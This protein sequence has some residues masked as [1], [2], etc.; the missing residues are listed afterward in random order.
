MMDL[1]LVRLVAFG[2]GLIGVPLLLA[3]AYRTWD[4]HHRAN[5]PHWRNGIGL[6]SVS[7]VA[8]VWLWFVLDL[9]SV[10]TGLGA[11]YIDGHGLPGNC[12]CLAAAFACAWKGR[13]RLEAVAACI[14]MV[15]GLS[16]LVYT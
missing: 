9:A 12:T 8:L 1:P 11:M 2:L 4:V 16:S 15:V 6:A 10:T 13:S 3:F 14:L 7:L 5:L